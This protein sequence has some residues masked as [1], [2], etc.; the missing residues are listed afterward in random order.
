MKAYK[1]VPLGIYLSL[2]ADC[3]YVN[4]P[5]YPSGNPLANRVIAGYGPGIDVLAW[6]NKSIR[7]EWSWNDLGESGFFLRINTGF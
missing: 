6:F 7:A 5:Y 4:D 3:G 1:K 2:N